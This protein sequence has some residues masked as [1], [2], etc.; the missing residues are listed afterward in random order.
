M[1]PNEEKKGLHYLGVKKSIC[2]TIRN[3]ELPP[4]FQNRKKPKSREKK[5]KNKDFSGIVIP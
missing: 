2:I 5:C 3:I 4:F 1:V